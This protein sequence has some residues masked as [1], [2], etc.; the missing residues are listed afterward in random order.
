M[1]MMDRLDGRHA[2][3]EQERAMQ[4]RFAELATIHDAYP[5][6]IA[7]A[8]MSRYPDLVQANTAQI[9]LPGCAA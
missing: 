9:E 7:R 8:F 3:T 6:K 1:E 5:T 4:A 2:H